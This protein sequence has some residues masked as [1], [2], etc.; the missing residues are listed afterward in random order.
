[1]KCRSASVA[2]L[3]AIFI[4]GIANSAQL[5]RACRMVCRYERYVCR[6]DLSKPDRPGHVQWHSVRWHRSGRSI[7]GSGPVPTSG[8]T[9]LCSA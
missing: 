7:F 3:F 1:M 2:L 6:I 9:R 5:Y 8:P 4:F